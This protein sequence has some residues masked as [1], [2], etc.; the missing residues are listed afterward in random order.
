MS[1]MPMIVGMMVLVMTAGVGYMYFVLKRTAK[2]FGIPVERKLTKGILIL[3]AIALGYS[4]SNMFSTSTMVILHVVGASVVVDLLNLVL[5]KGMGEK[6]RSGGGAIKV[7]RWLHGKLLLPILIMACFMLCGHYN[8]MHVRE[9]DFS[10]NSDKT[11]AI[12]EDGQYR[13]ALM[14]DIHYGI[15]IDDD[16][17][18]RMCQEIEEQKPDLV[19]LCG[20][21]VD[22]STTK[23]QMHTVFRELGGIESRYG[24][25]YVYGNHDRQLYRPEEERTFTE[26]ELADYI[27]SCGIRIL[28][29]ERISLNDEFVV[30]GR[31]DHSYERY[32]PR[33]SI[34]ELTEG[35]DPED[36]LLVLDHQPNEYEENEKAGTDLLLSGHTH[37]GQIWPGNYVFALLHINDAVY[38]E[39]IRDDFTAFVTSGV[40]GW[41][42]SVKTAA[43][44]EYV[45]ID[46]NGRQGK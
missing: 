17:L 40:A 11:F 24:A 13:I 16:G 30:V 19:V 35:V 32:E 33:K 21:I 8:M 28:K 44:A 10:M 29:D 34:R 26:D 23:E 6:Y 31:E 7:W 2:N 15:S 37:G 39:T 46:V 45:I 12:E 1:M 25:F 3:L 14:A 5:R 42:Y 38:K 43:P 27:E 22:E 4:C 20:D 41:G 36:F 18:R 9:T